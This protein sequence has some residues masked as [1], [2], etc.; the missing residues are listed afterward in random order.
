MHTL[1]LPNLP[2]PA[3]TD[4]SS[5]ASHQGSVAC[6]LNPHEWSG[7]NPW[8]KLYWPGLCGQSLPCI[9]ETR[10]LFLLEIH[11]NS[12][13][14]SWPTN[15]EPWKPV[16]S[17]K[18]GRC[19]ISMTWGFGWIWWA[20]GAAVFIFKNHWV[21]TLWRWANLEVILGRRVHI[22]YNYYIYSNYICT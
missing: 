1:H 13:S 6:I 4:E 18:I 11:C 9:S 15:C 3:S 8:Q 16:L 2:Q 19:W 22:M 10:A 20:A 17:I 5:L 7:G 14:L 21:A 12:P